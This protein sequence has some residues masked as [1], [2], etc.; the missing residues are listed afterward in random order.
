MT[1]SRNLDLPPAMVKLIRRL[2][3]GEIIVGLHAEA[4]SAYRSWVRSGGAVRGTPELDF[5]AEVDH[6]VPDLVLRARYRE[7]IRQKMLEEQGRED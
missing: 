4:I 2:A 3:C 7:I 1:S 6:A 5:M